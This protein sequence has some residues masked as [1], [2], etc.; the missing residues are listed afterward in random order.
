MG[1]FGRGTPTARVRLDIWSKKV[2]DAV[3]AQYRL[4][5]Y[6]LTSPC[7]RRVERNS[8]QGSSYTNSDQ[9]IDFDSYFLM[10]NLPYFVRFPTQRS[11]LINYLSVLPLTKIGGGQRHE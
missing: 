10:V 4:G 11:F 3:P 5:Q 8:S 6:T 7:N 2:F 9:G 1:V